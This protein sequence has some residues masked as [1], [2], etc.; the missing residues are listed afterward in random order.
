MIRRSLPILLPVLL[1]AAI[2]A[3]FAA[4]LAAQVG[5]TPESSPYQ[6]LRGRQALT[7]AVGSVAPGGDPAGV[8]P[9]TGLQFNTRY[10][11]LLTG[12][13]WLQVRG[14]YAPRLERTMK[15]PALTG[16]ARNVGT[17]TRPLT[18]LE[19]GFGL[20]LTGNKAW[21]GI[22]PQIHGALGMANGGTSNYD[23][24]GY[25][26]GNRFTISY[27]ASVR[28]ATGREWEGHIDATH[29]FWKYTYPDEYAG[30][31]TTILGDGKLGPW[32]G[33]LQLSVGVTR[34]FFR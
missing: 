13:L 26:F 34:Y 25:R 32:A 17:S 9:R 1:A 31:A 22:A 20:N 27:G 23:V 4:P 24:G 5:H 7:F 16:A 6:D 10:E 15:D 3:P 33:N 28:I 11:L 29:L 12:P 19:T 18:M 21:R 2:G 14:S 8:G 30:G